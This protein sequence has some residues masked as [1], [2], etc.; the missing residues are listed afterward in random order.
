MVCQTEC[1]L[2]YWSTVKELFE[3]IMSEKYLKSIKSRMGWQVGLQ[4]ATLL[5]IGATNANIKKQ[6]Q[7]IG[8]KLDS[9]ERETIQG[10]TDVTEAINSLECTLITGI[11]DLKWM[12]GSIDDKLGKIIG[13]IQY[14]SATESTEQFKIGMELYKQEF[15]KKSVSN[16]NLAVEKNPL[17]LNAK[18]GLF[19]AKKHVDKK[20]DYN[21]LFEVLRLVDSD[22]LFHIDNAEE[23]KE[24]SVNYFINFCFSELLI[25][26]DYKS[27][28]KFYESEIPNYS[29]EELA[30]KLKY[31]NAIILSGNNYET[32]LN[33]I[34]IEGKLE[35]L[36]IYFNYE[37]KNKHVVKFLKD[38]LDFLI[39][40]L[41]ENLL[42]FENK[43]FKLVVQKKAKYFHDN[44]KKNPDLLLKFGF[45]ENG[46]SNK[47]SKI[48]TF[49]DSANQ[50]KSR[51][52]S[53]EKV[54]KTSE[55]NLKIVKQISPPIF[56]KNEENFLN[57]AYNEMV[58]EIKQNISS[59]MTSTRNNLE[60]SIKNNTKQKNELEIYYPDFEDDSDNATRI[61]RSFLDNI[62]LDKKSINVDKIFQ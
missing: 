1:I 54:L 52:D 46:L 39:I 11:E 35:K 59:Y 41:P 31:I 50:S 19:L 26:K 53:L 8:D 55:T 13:L 44:I 47:I 45:Y 12:L 30:I 18:C 27:I 6:T 22:F 34:I 33:E 60:K 56:Y 40:R 17:N 9:L 15:Y 58:K 38:V 5:A 61:V 14:S 20:T 10:F 37:E 4:T 32:L 49:Y 62:D 29:R 21:L 43:D 42:S 16:F 2:A 51:F 3:F 36:L 7:I 48:K 24:R 25:G 23:V 28:I 57:D